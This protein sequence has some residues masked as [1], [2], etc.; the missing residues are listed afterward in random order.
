MSSDA[1]AQLWP[2][3]GIRVRS[4]DLELRWIDD[5]LLLDLAHV[6]GRGIHHPDRMPFATPWTRGTPDE[7]ARSVVAYQWGVRPQVGTE[8]WMLELGVLVDG[9][10][11]GIQGASATDWSVLRSAE[12]GSWLGREHQGRGI[13][14]RMRVLMLELLFTGLGARAATSGA[15]ADNP[16]SGAVS[17]RVGYLA[18]GVVSHPRE[19][20][21][22]AHDNFVLPRER[23]LE[24]R[25]ADLALLAAP[26]ELA[27][28]D[29]LRAVID[30]S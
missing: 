21:A 26:V 17:R 23:W 1:L 3:A 12:T 6:A 16:A 14:T 20:V 9:V 18:N 2:A 25:D 15:F 10:P 13:G 24:V 8:R 22:V 5:Q 4:G 28:V 29:A 11:V 30:A 19:G 7:V 27:G